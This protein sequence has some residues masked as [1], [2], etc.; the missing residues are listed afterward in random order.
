MSGWV[1]GDPVGD[2]VF[3]DLPAFGPERGGVLPS[4]RVAYETWG[5]L[6]PDGGNAVLVEHALTGDSHV[7]GPAGPGHATAGWWD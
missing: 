5:T 1:E 6:A 7:V 4:V 2:R 3:L